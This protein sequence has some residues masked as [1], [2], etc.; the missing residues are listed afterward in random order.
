M[1]GRVAA[2]GTGAAAGTGGT[3]D[4]GDHVGETTGDLGNRGNQSE[5]W[6]LAETLEYRSALMG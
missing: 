6:E 1:V 5:P 3:T 4:T 2:R